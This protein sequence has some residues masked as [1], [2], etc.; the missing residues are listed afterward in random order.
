MKKRKSWRCFHCDEI[1]RSRKAAWAHFGDDS[2][3]TKE[4]PAC[5]DP[6]RNDEKKRITDLR[7]AQKYALDM[8]NEARELDDRVDGLEMELAEFKALTKSSTINELRMKLDSEQ[9]RIVT[10]EALIEAVRSKAPDIY[11]EV[12]Q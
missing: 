4:L 3:C 1:F 12:I 5:I 6:L 11:R 8:E 7:E 2:Y 10:A 9:G